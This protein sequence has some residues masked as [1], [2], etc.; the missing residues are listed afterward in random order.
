MK[1][2]SANRNAVEAPIWDQST[3]DPKPAIVNAASNAKA[4]I[5]KTRPHLSPCCI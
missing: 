4:A 2:A 3:A 1:T 5:P